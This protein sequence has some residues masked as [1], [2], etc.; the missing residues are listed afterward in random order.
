MKIQIE[1][2]DDLPEE[3]IIIRCSQVTDAVQRIHNFALQQ[4]NAKAQIIFYKQNQEFFFSLD[5]ILFFE[6]EGERVYAH[7]AEDAYWIKHRLYELEALLPVH[8][9]RASKSTIINCK[10]IYSITRNLTSS[11]LIEFLHTHKRVYVSRRYY[12]ILKQKLE[13]RN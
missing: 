4:S 2:V 5:T 1:I 11:S 9:V 7:T 3:E 8:F 6:T 13:E 12:P 10:Q